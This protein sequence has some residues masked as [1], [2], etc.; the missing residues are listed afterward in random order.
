MIP[1]NE[2]GN[3]PSTPE[4]LS[5]VATQHLDVAN[6]SSLTVPLHLKHEGTGNQSIKLTSSPVQVLHP[7]IPGLLLAPDD[8]WTV[9]FSQE[10]PFTLGEQ[11]GGNDILALSL[12]LDDISADL[13]AD[14]PRYAKAGTYVVDLKA[15]YFSQPFVSHSQRITIVVDELNAVQVVAAGTNGLNR[16]WRISS[17]LDI[18][19]KYRQYPCSIFSFVYS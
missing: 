4:E 18:C 19:K 9:S 17:L 15:E 12:V 13:E 3:E 2:A 7:T 1:L 5:Q 6:S 16:A 11:G 8:Q 10:G 14:V